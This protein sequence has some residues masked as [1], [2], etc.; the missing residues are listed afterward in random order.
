MCVCMVCVCVC[1]CPWCVCVCVCLCVCVCV[2]VRARARAFVCV[3]KSTPARSAERND[4]LTT[5]SI[6]MTPC[7]RTLKG[8]TIH[9]SARDGA[10]PITSPQRSYLPGPRGSSRWIVVHRYTMQWKIFLRIPDESLFY[11]QGYLFTCV[12]L[13]RYPGTFSNTTV[14]L[15]KKKQ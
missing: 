7:T 11:W 4:K 3:S 8:T 12:R 1:V 13:P 14:A 10:P 9:M 6:L 2:C 15:K 5:Q